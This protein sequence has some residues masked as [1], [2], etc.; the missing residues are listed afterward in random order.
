MSKVNCVLYSDPASR[1]SSQPAGA[2]A[3]L[4][5]RGMGTNRTNS[6]PQFAD[7]FPAGGR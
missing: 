6:K 2:D 3:H 1:R 4:R 7:T 5:T